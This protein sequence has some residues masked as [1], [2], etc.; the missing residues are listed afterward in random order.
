MFRATLGVLLATVTAPAMEAQ[1][2]SA[3]RVHELRDVD[4]IVPASIT[5]LAARPDGGFYLLDGMEARVVQYSPEGRVVRTFGRFGQG[6]G[7]LSR[8]STQLL[9]VGARLAVV[10]PGNQRL[11]LFGLDGAFEGSQPLTLGQAL[12]TGWAR[13]GGQLVCL[14][15]PM[16]GGFGFDETGPSH[17]LWAIPLGGAGPERSL[18]RIRLKPGHDITPGAAIVTVDLSAP[19]PLLASGA[20][21]GMLL[22]VSDTYQIRVLDSAGRETAS[23]GRNVT[24]RRY[25]SS[26]QQRLRAEADS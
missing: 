9:L 2:W 8:L 20:G 1:V 15:P 16:P 12:A 24:P 11:N 23:L 5:H 18:L 17:T 10:D 26:E 14:S 7:E 4:G 22:A 19:K 6:P 3:H 25:S 13:A 21:G